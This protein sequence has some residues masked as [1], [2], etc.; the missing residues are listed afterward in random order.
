VGE[1]GGLFRLLQQDERELL[2]EQRRITE[3]SVRNKSKDMHTLSASSLSHIIRMINDHTRRKHRDLW[4]NKLVYR[5][6]EQ[7]LTWMTME[8]S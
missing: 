5:L 1:G 8:L 2:K 6:E 7:L 4:R 3:Q